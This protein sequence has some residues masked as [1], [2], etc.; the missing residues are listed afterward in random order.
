MNRRNF[1]QM[2]FRKKPLEK[3]ESSQITSGLMPYAG[4]WDT[5]QVVQLLRRTTFGAKKADIVQLLSLGMEASVDMLLVAQAA[6]APPVNNYITDGETPDPDVP[7]GQTWVN[8][9]FNST[10]NPARRNSLKAWWVGQ[11]VNQGLNITE[12]MT[13]FWHNHLA[14]EINGMDLAHFCYM[15]NA[16]LRQYALGNF[17]TLVRQMTTDPGMLRYLNGEQN[18]NTAPDENYARELQELFTVGKDLSP[19]YIEADVQAAARVL[20]G[21][22]NNYT[23]TSFTSFFDPTRH[24]TGNKQFSAF[25]NNTLIVGQ[26]GTNGTQELDQLLDMIFAQEEVAKFVCR[27]LYRFFVYYQIT[28]DAE[29][30]VIVPLADIFRNNNYEI[31]PVLDAL[32]KSEHFYDMTLFSCYIKN[33]LEFAIGTCRELNIAIPAPTVSTEYKAYAR[34]NTL[35]TAMEMNIGDPPNVSG[36]PAYYQTPL[37]HE[38]WL[39]TNTYAKRMEF[40]NILS[41]NGHFVDSGGYRLKA[42]YVTYVAT[43]ENPEDP[44]LLIDEA[45]LLLYTYEVS[46]EFKDYLKSFLLSGQTSDYYWT[47]AWGT[48]I[49]NP[50]TTNYNT[51]N[52]RLKAMFK[53]LLTQAEY[54]IC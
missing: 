15:N 28:P 7:A 21:Y 50:T 9:P 2:G 5:A 20:T 26:T 38:I 47:D 31:L 16:L 40:I 51:V 33:P 6:P 27:K 34:L 45:I 35:S 11:A 36:W 18:T 12:K 4:T 43:Y 3:N 44:N 42:N 37:F 8:A 49:A 53:Y 25:Y 22:R 30:N 52:S 14:T 13:L 39:N 1:L 46:Q 32:F 17:K 54:Q 24:D 41:E 19:S 10:Y 23:T 29:A 48:Y